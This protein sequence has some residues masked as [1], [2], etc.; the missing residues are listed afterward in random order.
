MYIGFPSVKTSIMS[1]K[2]VIMCVPSNNSGENMFDMTVVTGV[3]GTS[4]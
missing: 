1:D 2:N 3:L 4:T